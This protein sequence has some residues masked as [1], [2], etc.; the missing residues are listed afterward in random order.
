MMECVGL[1]VCVSV[2]RKTEKGGVRVVGE[3]DEGA[4]KKKNDKGFN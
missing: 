1:G 4:K 2:C 3:G